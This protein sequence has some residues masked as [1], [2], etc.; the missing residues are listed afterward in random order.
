MHTVNWNWRSL[1]FGKKSTFCQFS[2]KS[3]T[4]LALALL[5]VLAWRL[6]SLLA[7]AEPGVDRSSQ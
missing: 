2:T 1:F 7:K 5:V 4:F 6:P 3:T